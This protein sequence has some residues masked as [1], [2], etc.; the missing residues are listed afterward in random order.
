[1]TVSTSV[2]PQV[3]WLQGRLPIGG[4]HL[5]HENCNAIVNGDNILYNFMQVSVSVNRRAFGVLGMVYDRGCH[6]K[7]WER[8]AI[9]DGDTYFMHA[10]VSVARRGFWFW[11]LG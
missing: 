2:T 9:V 4:C 6:L 11:V 10:S 5:Q 8:N 1:M 3:L 7:C